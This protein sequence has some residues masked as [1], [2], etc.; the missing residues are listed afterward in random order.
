MWPLCVCV[1]V[2]VCVLHL[3]DF[4]ACVCD[5]CVC[6]CEG[7][8]R[9][10]VVISVLCGGS[11]GAISAFVKELWACFVCTYVRLVAKRATSLG[12]L[13]ILSLSP[14]HPQPSISAWVLNPQTHHTLSSLSPLP[15]TLSHACPC[16]LPHTH[17]C[18]LLT[19]MAPLPLPS[20]CPSKLA[21]AP[22]LP[23]HAHP[24]PPPSA[25]RPHSQ[26]GSEPQL[27]HDAGAER[28]DQNVGRRAQT[29]HDA[30]ALTLKQRRPR[31]PWERTGCH[32]NTQQ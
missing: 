27:L 16:P 4:C 30:D 15:L 2:C 24:R 17:S 18:P 25:P 14:T 12:S 29:P 26:F 6:E 7:E 8:L 13:P 5:L 1:C 10:W 3:C 20:P 23:L 22:P 9:V 31:D 28:L 19:P 21:L 11:E 32:V